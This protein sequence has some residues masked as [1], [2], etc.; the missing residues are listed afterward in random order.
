MS[1]FDEEFVNTINQ[2][3]RVGVLATADA[4]GKPNAA[5]FGS[6]RLNV[7]GQLIMGMM[8]N[9]SLA[10]LEANPYAVFFTVKEAPV[11]FTTPGWRL[12]L[13]CKQIDREG[14]VLAK[15]K[16]AVAAGAGEAAA[17]G[18]KAGIVFEVTKIRPLVDTSK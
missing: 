11:G 16:K 18:I 12:Y 6:P 7:E 2:P 4:D 3:G 5:Y 1:N 10:N 14:E 17:A 8:E 15:V 13:E 9:R